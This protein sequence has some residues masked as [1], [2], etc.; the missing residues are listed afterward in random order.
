MNVK[1]CT[2]DT[3]MAKCI[4]YARDLFIVMTSIL[5]GPVQLGVSAQ[6]PD[7]CAALAAL[8]FPNTTITGAT[9]VEAGA[10]SPPSGRRGISEPFKELGAFCRIIT[11]TRIP[12]SSEAKSE[13]WLPIGGWNR[14]LQPAGGGFYGGALPYARMREILRLG[15]ATSGSDAGI[16]GGGLNV[17]LAHPEK[18]TNI[19][20]APIHVMID[21]AKALAMAFYGTPPRVTF[22]DECGGGGSRDVLAVV[23]RWPAD[24]D[25]A[26]AVGATNFGTHHGLAQMWLYWATHKD[27][28]SY[29]P[30]EKYSAIHQAALDACDAKDG[31]KDGIIEDPPHCK[32]DPG[33]M[34]CKGADAPNCLTAPQV[35][36]VRKIY[37]T[38][39][40]ARTKAPLYGPM[41]PGSELSWEDMTAR[42]RPYPYAE[43]FYRNMVFH[44]PNWDYKTFRPDFAADVDR[45]DAPQNLAINA[46]NPDLAPFVDRGGKLLMMGGWNDDLGPGNNVTYYES[47]VA[48]IG[49]A[50]ARTGVRLFM[51][52]GMHHCLALE[53]PSTYRVDFDLPGAITQ[54][55]QTG[56]AP[57]QIVVNTSRPGQ[58]PRRRLVCAYPMV[59]RYKG[60]GNTDDPAN[61]KCNVP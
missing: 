25:T 13:I 60:T 17:A 1:S 14:E 32:F 21:Q 35:A 46:T 34:Q 20:N 45:A 36:A 38:P 41:V 7:S 56:E 23:Q 26:S 42:P 54:W 12:P 11:T 4:R 50:K 9:R 6:Q 16:E 3:P 30:A 27:E 55:K 57:N 47:V 18:L 58:P 48:T 61:F 33:V 31:V 39:R 8:I 24:L 40:H 2:A 10:F 37:E 51:V 59:S 15:R 28:A 5:C 29:I 43:A 19:G 52:P 53:Y 49:A 22:M 44:D